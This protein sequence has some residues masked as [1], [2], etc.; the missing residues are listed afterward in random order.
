MQV[1]VSM[2][3]TTLDYGFEYL[4]N[5]IRSIKSSKKI[6]SLAKNSIFTNVNKMD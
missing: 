6:T 4:G 3:T 1:Q 2:V 5:P